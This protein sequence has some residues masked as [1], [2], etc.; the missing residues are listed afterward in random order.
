[1]SAFELMQQPRRPFL[2]AEALKTAFRE[3]S[4]PLHPDR[5]HH[6]SEGEKEEATRRFAELN[7]AYLVLRTPRDRINLLLE[8]ETGARP[9]DIQRIP[10]GTMD[11]FVEVGQ[12]CRDVDA[13][14]E[15]RGNS[16]SS[17]IL[18]ASGLRQQA[19]WL[20]RLQEILQKVR[21]RA[22]QAEAELRALDAKWGG[23]SDRRPLLEPLEN[24]ARIF[25][26]IAR[27]NSQIEERLVRLRTE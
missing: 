26:Y 24:L 17:P 1:M 23:G 6:L 12:T 5:V 10:S 3:L 25:S 8:Q 22:D 20:A 13:F 27:W 4:G 9:K 15:S 7:A 16:A 2:D 19:Q 18:H 21:V 11:L 14:L